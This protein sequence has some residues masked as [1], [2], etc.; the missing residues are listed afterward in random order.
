M[1]ASKKRTIL[2]EEK[3]QAALSDIISRDYFPEVEELKKQ[4][5]L[6]QHRDDGE[7]SGGVHFVKRYRRSSHQSEDGEIDERYTTSVSS[8]GLI[9]DPKPLHFESLSG[10]HARVTSEDN[11]SF[12]QVQ[13]EEIR[14]QANIAELCSVST[15]VK[16]ELVPLFEVA[17]M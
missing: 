17:R 2:K 1:I 11:A 8:G 3:Y 5:G 15:A 4:E 13:N 14:Q 12:D 7:S 10:F 16:K 6:L 9:G